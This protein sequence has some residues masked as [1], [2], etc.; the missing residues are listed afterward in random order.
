MRLFT[1]FASAALVLVGATSSYAADSKPQQDRMSPAGKRAAAAIARIRATSASATA[2]ASRSGPTALSAH[3][4]VQT[5][6]IQDEGTCLNKADC[7]EITFP[8]TGLQLITVHF[9]PGI[10]LASFE[11]VPKK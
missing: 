3:T 7:G 4:L 1:L 6:K 2:G 11:F 5:Q 9:L 8:Q 10:N